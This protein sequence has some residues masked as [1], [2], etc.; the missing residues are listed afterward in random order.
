[1]L[2][3]FFASHP[4]LHWDDEIFHV[5]FF[6]PPMLS[7]GFAHRSDWRFYGTKLFL[8]QIPLE[9][10]SSSVRNMLRKLVSNG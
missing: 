5:N 8:H 10:Q 6:N 2:G 4:K 9:V 7:D 3:S 1:M